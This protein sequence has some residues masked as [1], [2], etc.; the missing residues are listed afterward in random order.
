M[1]DLFPDIGNTE[2]GDFEIT[3]FKQS[4]VL[5][6]NFNTYIKRC[7]IE[8]Q[9]G[10]YNNAKIEIDKAINF[11]ETYEEKV[12]CT[13]EK[14]RV[15]KGKDYFDFVESNLEKF[16]NDYGIDFLLER[17]YLNYRE[18]LIEKL[19]VNI[20][21][22]STDLDIYEFYNC[23]K[24]I[25]ND[26]NIIK[27]YLYNNVEKFYNGTCEYEENVNTLVIRTYDSE[28]IS[29]EEFKSLIL[30]INNSRMISKFDKESLLIKYI[31]YAIKNNREYDFLISLYMN[32]NDL[33]KEKIELLEK[34]LKK[35]EYF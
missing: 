16:L 2:F 22:K 31:V 14:I 13:K 26:V 7:E 10:N 32:I 9:K 28:I 29:K 18:D 4:K 34:N 8:L 11:A 12:H 3:E 1:D 30:K 33:P 21:K 17:A 35:R 23:S 6:T 20:I 24:Y 27:T 25:K 15:L 19:S 5:D